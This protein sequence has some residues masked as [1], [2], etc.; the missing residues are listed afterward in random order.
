MAEKMT[1]I[2][3]AMAAITNQPVDRLPTYPIACGV[4]RRL[5]KTPTTYSEWCRDP[6]KYAGAFCAGQKYF[7]Y[8]FA[9]GLMDLSVMAGELGSHVRM[10]EQ[11]TPFVDVPVIKGPEDYEKLEVPD[12]RKGRT[13]VI[14]QGTKMYAEALGKEVVTAGFIEGPLLVLTQSASAEKVFMDMYNNP[15]AVHKALNTITEFDADFTRA[16]GSDAKPAGL[17]WDYLW[18]SY[19]CLGDKEYE[20]FE[21]Q[22]ARKLNQLTADSGMAFCVHNCA[23]L[24]HLDV[25]VKAWK[26]VIYSMAYYPLIPGSKPAGQVIKEGYADNTL[27]AGNID[28]QGFVRWAPEKMQRVTMNLCKEVVSA[29]KERGLGGRYVTASGCEVPPALSTKLENIKMC[30]DTTKQYG[31]FA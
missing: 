31:T 15:S 3:R 17:V 14:L 10:D 23:D 25:Q 13:G 1:H 12:V 20:D 26:P 28:P 22:Y 4:Q 5:L 6:K 9:I 16:F 29:L 30:V 7:D 2:E 19:S 27:M 18:G 8:D 24:P 21:G 11:N